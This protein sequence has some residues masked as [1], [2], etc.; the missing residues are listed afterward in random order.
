MR[1]IASPAMEKIGS[2]LDYLRSKRNV[3]KCWRMD[4]ETPGVDDSDR[5]AAFILRAAFSEALAEFRFDEMLRKER[6]A[7]RRS[8]RKDGFRVI[9]LLQWN[10]PT[11]PRIFK[12]AKRA[13]SNAFAAYPELREA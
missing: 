5:Q 3:S 2:A 13:A 9:A 1:R 7:L 6:I 8:A 11:D 12:F 4:W 10:D